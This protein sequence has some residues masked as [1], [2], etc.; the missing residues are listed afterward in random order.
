M[1]SQEPFLG[2]ERE[3]PALGRAHALVRRVLVPAAALVAAFCAGALW[4][5][6]SGGGSRAWSRLAYAVRAVEG[7][8]MPTAE[9][10]RNNLVF[11][12]DFDDFDLRKWKHEIT[13]SAGGN[14]EFQWYTNNRSNT[15]V[16]NGNLHFHPTL[17]S[18]QFGESFIAE[19]G[20]L[21]IWGTTPSSQCTSNA[22]WGCE[23]AAAEG[24]NVLPPVQSAKV[25]T[26]ESFSFKYGRLEVRAKLPRGDWLWPAVWLLPKHEM[27]GPWPASGEIDFMES[28]G[29]ANRT[30]GPNQIGSTLHW[31]PSQQENPWDIFHEEYVLPDG[32]DFCDEYHIFGLYWDED[33]IYTY[34]D[35]D[36]NKV[37][38]AK[39]NESFWEKGMRNRPHWQQSYSNP[40]A[41]SKNIDAPYDQEFY[42]V[43]NLAVGGTNGYFNKTL[44]DNMPWRQLDKSE[45]ARH[46]VNH[47]WAAK[48]EWYSTWKG[49]EQDMRVDWVKVWQDL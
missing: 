41:A 34:V 22:F 42:L 43:M 36:D 1:D 27:Y 30:S 35:T 28:R 11:S 9:R 31:G 26:F 45:E 24:G 38:V 16:K 46:A 25:R 15:F 32:T 13:M 37:L 8:H 4:A 18:E 44:L 21:D 19:S 6:G 48:D 12:D 2:G 10:F 14:W 23:R 39:F 40:W 47:F 5:D 20:R 33:E 7:P 3:R 29:N 17:T 49:E